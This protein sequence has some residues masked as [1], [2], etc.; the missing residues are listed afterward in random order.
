MRSWNSRTVQLKEDLP[1][2]LLTDTDSYKF[3]H[4]GLYPDGTTSMQSHLIARGGEFDTCTLAG[5]QYI[6]HKYLAKPITLDMIEEAESF[7]GK[8]G[9]PFNKED[10]L[11]VMKKYGY[12]PVRIRAIPEGLVVPVKSVL[13][14]VESMVEDARCFWI[15]SWIEDIL[16]RLW[17]PSTIATTSRE[18]KKI[19]KEYLDLSSDDPE[20]EIGFKLHDFGARGVA[21]LEQ[22][23]IGGAA[24]LFSF[25]GSDTVEGIRHA[26]HYY[27]CEMAGFSIPAT[28][29]SVMAMWGANHEI[30][31]CENFIRKM[32]IERQVPAGSPK[33]A[34]CVSD[35]YN[36]FEMF[37]AWTHPFLLDLIKQSGGTLV[38]RPDSGNPLTVLPTLF[39]ILQSRLPITI[40]SKGYKLL[41]SYFRM[42]QGDGIDMQ[43]TRAICKTLTD[44]KWSISNIAFGSG[45]GLL[46]KVNRDTQMIAF[47]NNHAIINGKS[48]AVRK[49]P[50]TDS[51]KA[52]LGG[53]LDLALI[54]GVYKNV[55]LDLGV[56]KHPQSVMNTVFEM[57][58]VMYHTTM[59]ACRQRMAL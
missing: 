44:L 35:T 37:K 30:S 53:R 17:Y 57:G 45:G 2:N 21:T 16:E 15:V 41:P 1:Y 13:A 29:H 14:T 3:S 22:A 54:D 5:L 34:A 48:V 49:N 59:D 58:D 9:E 7:A 56:D 47:K 20:A 6:L 24:H 50:I 8:H 10:W 11:Y 39:E 31:C 25:F 52:S 43:S 55:V 23:R 51:G 19:I 4:P 28:E 46:Q 27:D 18:S 36:V 32:L 38:A 33:F 26:N 12:L 42:I 40:N